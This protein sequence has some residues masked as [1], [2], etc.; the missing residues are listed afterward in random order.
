M[1]VENMPDQLVNYKYIKI[2]KDLSHTLTPSV[3]VTYSINLLVR[4]F[5]LN[6]CQAVTVFI[7]A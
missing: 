7:P 4:M 2:V 5:T 1:V 6:S 3:R